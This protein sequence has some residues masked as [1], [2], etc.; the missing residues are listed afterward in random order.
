[1]SQQTK[2]QQLTGFLLNRF[3]AVIQRN[4]IDAWMERG[5]LTITGTDQGQGYE[6]AQWKYQAVLS[7]EK[8]PHRKTDP[9]ILFAQ[10]AAWLADN[11][12]ERDE[13]DLADPAI[14][15]DVVSKDH[16]ELLI[17]VELLDKLGLIP[18]EA[19]DVLFNGQNYKLDLVPFFVADEFEQSTEVSE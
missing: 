17:E 5:Q 4:E 11:D 7:I 10:V 19:G 9:Y 8:F 14:D 3:G 18:D 12:P 6:M 13:N 2:L 16:A 1:M 15:I